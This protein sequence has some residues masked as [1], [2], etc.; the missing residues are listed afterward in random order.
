MIAAI[1][2]VDADWGI[3]YNGELL[4]QIPEDMK[5]FKDLTNNKIVVM[6]RKTWDSLPIKPLPNRTNIVITH[7]GFSEVGAYGMTIEQFLWIRPLLEESCTIFIIGGSEIYKQLLPYC[8][9]IF[10]TQIHKSHK[11]V[12]TYFPEL[13]PVEWKL[14]NTSELKEYNGI[15]YSFRTFARV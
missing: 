2:A 14:V 1:V 9:R 8:D 7:K 12:D 13:R 10:M 4:E 11:N 15:L 6:G 3:G 5:H